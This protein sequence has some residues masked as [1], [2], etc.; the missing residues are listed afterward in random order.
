MSMGHR[1]GGLL[2]PGLCLPPVLLVNVIFRLDFLP[3]AAADFLFSFDGVHVGH[4]LCEVDL[5]S[6]SGP[7]RLRLS[8][9][10]VT[11]RLLPLSV[12]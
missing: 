7:R 3:T 12:S 10:K 9:H 2:A 11:P 8:K 4:R 1:H 5:C 6:S